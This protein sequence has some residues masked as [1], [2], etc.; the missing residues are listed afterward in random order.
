ME[1]WTN[2]HTGTSVNNS[3]SIAGPPFIAKS[4][5]VSPCLALILFKITVCPHVY[6]MICWNYHLQRNALFFINHYHHYHYHYHHHHRHHHHNNNNNSNN[7]LFLSSS[8][9]FWLLFIFIHPAPVICSTPWKLFFKIHSFFG[10]LTSPE[11]FVSVYCR[12]PQI[13]C[14]EAFTRRKIIYN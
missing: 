12:G 6:I 14:C 3:L 1:Q 10:R 8:S 5:I 2:C 7:F 9:S 11:L 4:A 13:V